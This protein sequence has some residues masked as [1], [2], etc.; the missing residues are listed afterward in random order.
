MSLVSRA[1]AAGV[2]YQQDEMFKVLNTKYEPILPK[3][4]AFVF[5]SHQ[6]LG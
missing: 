3:T 5:L 1:V 4:S 2:A 6:N